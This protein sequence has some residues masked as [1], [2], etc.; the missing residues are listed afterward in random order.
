[1]KE[2]KTRALGV[3]SIKFR[4][5]HGLIPETSP[6]FPHHKEDKTRTI[7]ATNTHSNV[8]QERQANKTPSFSV[9]KHWKGWLFMCG[10]KE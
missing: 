5:Y 7:V 1:M 3:L 8:K 6:E 10:L 9:W 4:W 2:T